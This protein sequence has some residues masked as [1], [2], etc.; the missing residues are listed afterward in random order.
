MI[1]PK[2]IPGV[3]PNHLMPISVKPSLNASAVSVY[4]PGGGLMDSAVNSSVKPAVVKDSHVYKHSTT[5]YPPTL[6]TV[7]RGKLFTRNYNILN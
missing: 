6:Y 3:I 4:I 7:R 2:D 1:Y 5:F